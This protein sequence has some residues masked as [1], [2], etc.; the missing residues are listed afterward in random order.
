M[1]YV[2]L[3]Y[4]FIILLVGFKTK[5]SK[6]A[7]DFIYAGRKLTA[8]P[9]AL[10]LV[11]TWYGAISIIGQEIL[12]N[13]ISTWLYFGLGY[14]VAAYVYSEFISDRIIERNISSLSDG[15]LKYMGKKSALISIPIILLYI[16]PAPYLIMLG[17]IIN[18]IAF[19]S[20]EFGISVLFGTIISILYCFKGGFKSIINTDRYQFYFMFSGFLL[21][22]IYIVFFYDY[23]FKKLSII[24]ISKPEL[25]SIP[26][27]QGWPY[28][29]A[30]GLIAMLTFIDPSFHQRTFASKN[31]Q[32]IKK[33]IR[34][35]IVCWFVFDMMTLF[36]GL[37][38][39]N[40]DTP[41]ISLALDIFQN[42]PILSGLFIISILSIIMSTI[43]SFTF[44]S[45]ITIGKDSRNIFN[46][47]HSQ[48][49][50]NWGIFL[51]IVISLII[52]LCFDNTRVINIWFTFGSYMASG[53]LIPFLFILFNINVKYPVIL[54]SLPI[55]LT[56]IWD[57]AQIDWMISMY[58]GLILSFLLGLLLRDRANQSEIEQT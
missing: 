25:F 4:F 26:G 28:I 32:E 57:I 21:M 12:Y 41:Y 33:G 20:K 39:I 23:G 54:I 49:H 19:E 52:I 13:G 50:I 29:L 31:K 35:S 10:T 56:L 30:W 5:T 27:S 15:I 42:Y 3:I 46:K 7:K 45:A 6:N 51:S 11:T 43:D 2:I 17:N 44:I 1:I 14:Y 9:L 38:A 48:N 24:Y 36:C 53:L 16:S 22:F 58:P 37:Y 34:I 47:E 8:I 55:L 40:P 18:T